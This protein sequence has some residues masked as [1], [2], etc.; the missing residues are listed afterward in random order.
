MLR[1]PGVLSIAKLS[2]SDAPGRGVRYYVEHIANSRDDYYN[3]S[4]EAPGRWLGRG[5]E[6][7]GLSGRVDA[8]VYLGVMEGRDPATGAALVP[9]LDDRLP[10]YDLTFAAPKSASLLWA[11]GEPEVAEAVRRAHSKAVAAAL[12]IAEEE[13]CFVRRGAGGH[14]VYQGGG[15]V[16]AAFEHRSS[17]AGD[18]HLHTHVVIANLTQGPD[19]RWSAPDGRPLYAWATSLGALYQAQLRAELA[20]LGLSW[21]ARANGMAEVS[22]I[23]R[24]ILRGF[25]RR[26][27][28]IEA[29]QSRAGGV[30]ARS[31]EVAQRR[32]RR[33]KDP[34]LAA[35]PDQTLRQRWL[36][37][38]ETIAVRG[39]PGRVTDITGAIQR[40]AARLPAGRAW[41][42]RLA[43]ELVA[44]PPQDLDCPTRSLTAHV[45]TFSRRDVVRSLAGACPDGASARVVMDAAEA[46][47]RSKAVV[48]LLPLATD[49]AGSTLVVRDVI[50]TRDGR[51]LPAIPADRRYSTP[52]LLAIEA[53]ILNEAQRLR[54]GRFGWVYRRQVDAMLAVASELSSDQAAVVE[55]LCRS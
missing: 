1:G 21:E 7:L 49:P 54:G 26:R 43:D 14:V 29:D 50:R 33:P 47:V 44:P 42:A 17:R 2:A 48:P 32:T 52:D 41:L 6:A 40:L 15:F 53:G 20:E 51:V 18:P 35:A 9:L 25:S 12:A 3:G 22:A 4:G 36:G 39:R 5:T 24:E 45:S 38:L 34:A 19:R 31:A 8:E 16:A 46:L 37:Q 11:F 28:E 30:S 27:V 13:A 23:P 10:G 55:G